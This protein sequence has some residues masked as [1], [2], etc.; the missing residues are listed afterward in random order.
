MW[1]PAE[2]VVQFLQRP[3]PSMLMPP[4]AVR[5]DSG[6]AL[7]DAGAGLVMIPADLSIHINDNTRYTVLEMYIMLTSG[8]KFLLSYILTSYHIIHYCTLCGRLSQAAGYT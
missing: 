7:V 4:A 1:A 6:Q 5:G 3:Y 2:A 8:L